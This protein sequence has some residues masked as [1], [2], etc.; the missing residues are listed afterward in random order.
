MWLFSRQENYTEFRLQG[1]VVAADGTVDLS[2]RLRTDAADLLAEILAHPRKARSTARRVYDLL[3]GDPQAA[4]WAL[5]AQRYVRACG[6]STSAAVALAG[7]PAA[8]LLSLIEP[9]SPLV[10]VLRG[11]VFFTGG[12]IAGAVVGKIIGLL[13]ARRRFQARTRAMMDHLA[14]QST[15]LTP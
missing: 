11:L 9:H 13:G 5:E 4:I 6:C 10:A 12:F 3:S 14:L 8:A 15:T 7:G 1:E 2:A